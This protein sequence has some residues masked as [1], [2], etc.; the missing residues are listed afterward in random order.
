VFRPKSAVRKQIDDRGTSQAPELQTSPPAASV[1]WLHGLGADGY[2]LSRSCANWSCRRHQ[3]P[4]C[5]SACADARGDDQRRLRDAAWY[6]ILGNDL[7][8]REDET[9]IRESQ[10]QVEAIIAREVDRAHR[11]RASCWLASRRAARSRRTRACASEPVAGLLV[12]SAYLPLAATFEAERHQ[13]ATAPILMAHGRGD[14]V[15]PPRVRSAHAT[16]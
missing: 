2:D 7:V 10:R 15:I 8:R 3:P 13:R 12:L 14:P 6:D 9:G 11:A 16:S 4:G 1:I 5:V